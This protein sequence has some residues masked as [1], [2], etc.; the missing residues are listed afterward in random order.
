MG[1]KQQCLQYLDGEPSDQVQTKSS[2]IR[3]LQK[4]V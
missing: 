1:K 3:F 4:L 2:E